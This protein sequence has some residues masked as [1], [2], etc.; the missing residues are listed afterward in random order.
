[1]LIVTAI[2]EGYLDYVR[3][4]CF[5]ITNKKRHKSDNQMNKARVKVID[6]GTKKATEIACEGN[7]TQRTHHSRCSCWRSGVC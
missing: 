3:F 7:N 2:N 4:V 6:R 1:M 5:L